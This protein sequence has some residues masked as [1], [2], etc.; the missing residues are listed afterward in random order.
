MS[1]KND[2]NLFKAAGG[3]KIKVKKRPITFYLTWVLVFVFIA[4]AGIIA[5]FVYATGQQ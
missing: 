5:Y 3:G 1:A 4:C 2:I